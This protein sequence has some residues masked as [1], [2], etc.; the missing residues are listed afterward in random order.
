MS[1]D[2][3]NLVRSSAAQ[4]SLT[5]SADQT[6]AVAHRG[7]PLVIQGGPGTGK[8]TVL[9]EAAL[10]RINEG[11][12]PDSIL[13]LTYGRERA[14][15]LRD[16][17]ALRTTK[18][19]FEPL[20]RTFHSLAFSI[21]KMKAH[22]QDP[23]PILLSG[24]EQESH[25]KELLAG[26][27]ADGYKEWPADLH[28]ALTTHGFA[29][30]LRDLILRASER[31]IN[32][33]QLEKL[34][35]SEGEKFWLAAAKF[36][37]RYINSMVMRESSAS[38]AKMRIDPSEL[39]SRATLHLHNNPDVLA[40]LRDR[41]TTI[42]V[43]EFQESD[44]AQRALLS[45]LVGQD[46]II[47]AD[48][49]SAVGRFRGADP[50][51]LSAALDPY[52]GHE[53]ILNTGF[54]SA[55]TI[56]D[57]GHAYVQS[58]KG[59]PVTR[60]RSCGNENEGSVAV[61]RFRS[62]AEEAAFIAHQFRSAHLREGISY[63]NMAVILRNPG[64][65]ASALRRAFSY[66]GIPVASEL[67]ALAGNPAIAPFLLLARVAIKA[68]PLNLDTAERLL[69]SEFG[70]A[71]SISLRRIRRAMIAA[72]VDGDERSG[73]Q[74]LVD[75][76]DDGQL[77]IEGADSI[78]RV[79]ALLEKGRAVARNKSATADDLLW[80]LWDNAV[81]SDG[82]KLAHAWRTQSLRPGVRGAA[83]DRDL[84]A[85]MQLFESAARYSERFPLS[86]PAAFIAEIATEDI[87]GDVITAK[88]VRPD[89]VEILT[90]HSAKG[91]EWDLVAVAG[92]QEGTWPN[93]KQRSSLLGAE[94]LVER[95]R[96]P[97]IPRD[98][99]DVIAASGLMQDEARLFH[100]AL[101]RAK[102]SLFVT[103]VQRDD[104]EPSVFFEH[105][106]V[107]VNKTDLA[108]PELTDVPRPITAPALVAELRSQLHGPHAQEAAALLKRLSENGIY[109]ADP[110]SWVGSVPIST[111]APVIDADKEVIVSP[112]GAESFVECGVKWFLQ[113]NGGTDG[114]STAQVL[115]SAIHAFAAK[116]VQEPG[117]TQEDLISHLSSSWKL[118]DPDSGWVSASHLENAVTMLKKFV[119]YHSKTTR[120]VVDAE[121][122]FDVTLGRARIKGSVDRLEVEADGSLFI[123]DFK[124]G[125]SAISNKDAKE[126]LQ[127][128]SYQVGIAEGGFTQGQ[129][130][131][132]AELV[133]LGTDAAS[134]TIRPQHG[135]DLEE[136]KTQLNEIADG[137]GAATFFAT[138]NK[139][140]KGCPVRKSCPVQ[141]DGRT[142]IS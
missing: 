99:L 127:L 98:Q 129:V 131:A 68:Q 133:Y 2:S 82:Q 128:K 51:G 11:Q 28:A 43:D 113:N 92:L 49:D 96:N 81:T 124:T 3:F 47:C 101:T 50:D 8:T 100:V 111:D 116:M 115:G 37:Q 84:D 103:A 79:H 9:I 70:G 46:V 119:D 39:V 10:S 123:I 67:Q 135:I 65:T 91:R 24:P 60:K 33:V 90:V 139:R 107:M 71:D 48:A 120:T 14:S 117:T 83:A 27:I 41:F 5:L 73:T 19:M 95:Q 62:G 130:S 15:Q 12:N 45:K 112:S 57:V 54:R 97:D 75:A 126:N 63:S 136:V 77:F 142:V 66:V 52:R 17:V 89:F 132:G 35:E 118:I 110:A 25:I 140:C 59:S 31:G 137:M 86:G 69:M 32:P 61:N 125:G 72:R 40:K 78:L 109:L 26:D 53:I 76:I 36:W 114:D 94:R 121:M 108:E 44:P 23:E 18:T 21:I 74:L 38:D 42:M 105:I 6:A 1:T 29:R 56:F 16:A 7:S 102:Q 30:E 88:G 122:R 58:I 4:T 104:E 93:L 106:E 138:I 87:A 80:A 134:A 20:A 141:S 22:S 85:M 13:L 55:S 64:V 34:G